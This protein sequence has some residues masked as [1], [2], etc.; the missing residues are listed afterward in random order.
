MP[1]IKKAKILITIL[2]EEAAETQRLS[3]FRGILKHE[4][5]GLEYQKKIRNEWKQRV[6]ILNAVIYFLNGEEED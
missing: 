4:I 6:R 1:P 2:E 3:R 5:D